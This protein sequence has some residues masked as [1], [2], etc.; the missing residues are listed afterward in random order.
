M[1]ALPHESIKNR[2]EKIAPLLTEQTRRCRAAVE[3]QE[4]GYGGIATVSRATGITPRAITHGVKELSGDTQVEM[5]KQRKSGGG[6]KSLIE[7]H[8]G[9]LDALEE[10]VEPYSS[11]DPT[12][13]LRQTCKSTYN[14]SD[15]LKN[16]GFPVSPTSV[17]G[18]LKKSGYSLQS[19]R[20]RFEG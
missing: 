17:R 2:Y 11:G 14:L 19:N 10:L 4:L 1:K 5:G 20:K 15:E 7:K 18:L 6:R 12:K 9:V 3:A 8:P 13:P 16:Q